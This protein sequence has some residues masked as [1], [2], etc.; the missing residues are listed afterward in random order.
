L[1]VFL[2]LLL[3]GCSTAPERTL[4]VEPA[5]FATLPN[6]NDPLNPEKLHP[7]I[8]T[9]T[10]AFVEGAIPHF[11]ALRGRALSILQLSGGGQYGAFGAGFLKGWRESGTRPEFDIV[12]GVSAGALLGTHAFLGTPADDAVLEEVFT[13]M[14]RRDIYH[15]RGLI[16]MAFDASSVFDTSPLRALLDKYIT[17]DV[18][19]RVGAAHDEGRRLLVGTTNLDYNQTWIW[20]MGLIAKESGVEALELYKNVLLASAS[21]PIAFP[22]VEIDGHLFADGGVRQNLVVIGLAGTQPP[23]RPK[24]GPGTVY[25]VHN[26]KSDTPPQAIRKNSRSIAGPVLNTM[27]S[28][29]TANLLMRSY[30]AAHA[31]G[32]DFKLVSIPEDT[33]AGN[34]ALAFDNQQMRNSFEAGYRLALLPDP[35]LKEP[36]VVKDIPKWALDYVRRSD[37]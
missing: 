9:D 34:N 4:S 24:Y 33:D 13:Q 21:P 1:G 18:L 23:T 15:R 10:P 31:R 27:L 19:R 12:T 3:V 36:D 37:R 32:Y 25:V 5:D 8:G 17:E 16:G 14:S 22:P 6:G 28:T 30:F 26:G 11:E 20:D 2:V 35:W 7:H 29:S